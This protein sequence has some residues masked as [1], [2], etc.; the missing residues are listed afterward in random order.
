MEYLLLSIICLPL[1][2]LGI[3]T[4]VHAVL[5]QN[6]FGRNKKR[7]TFQNPFNPPIEPYLEKRYTVDADFCQNRKAPRERSHARSFDDS[8]EPASLCH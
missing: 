4:I 7:M 3:R 6:V 2:G 8:L 1:V 5:T